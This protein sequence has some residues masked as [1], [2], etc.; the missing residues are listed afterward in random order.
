MIK[1]F[2]PAVFG[3]SLLFASLALTGCDVDE[4]ANQLNEPQS[5]S[6]GY[7]R[8]SA[9][10]YNDNYQGN[11]YHD[12]RDRD[13]RYRDDRYDNDH[14]N[15]DH[16]SSQAERN[17]EAYKDGKRVGATD[18]KAG[19]DKHYDKHRDLY[20]KDTQDSFKDGYYSGYEE[21]RNH[22]KR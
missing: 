6:G 20:D 1:R 17:R 8:Q 22:A 15:D 10:G 14:H 11:R 4:I 7:Q 2:L 12:D 13:D 19:R 16:S 5:N 9:Y 18:F 21:A 3:S